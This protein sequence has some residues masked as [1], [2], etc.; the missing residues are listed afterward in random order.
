MAAE[1]VVR[2]RT[3]RTTTSRRRACCTMPLV[4][5]SRG[6]FRLRTAARKQ[7]GN[8]TR[9][10]RGKAIARCLRR[11]DATERR[12][13]SGRSRPP[14]SPSPARGAGQPLL[15]LA[16]NEAKNYALAC[17]V[18]NVI[19]VAEMHN[20]SLEFQCTKSV[21]LLEVLGSRAALRKILEPVPA[22]ARDGD[23]GRS[24]RF[25]PRR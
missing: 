24:G 10:R 17:C 3:M 15:S 18:A 8:G 6:A 16:R 12:L 2:F 14:S 21:H 1:L 25:G 7:C 23:N 19:A 11:I 20:P 13:A 22:S 9:T 5:G 4:Y